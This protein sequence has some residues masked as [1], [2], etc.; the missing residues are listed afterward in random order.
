MEPRL[1]IQR[2]HSI[3]GLLSRSK[4]FNKRSSPRRSDRRKQ[5]SQQ[6]DARL[7]LKS[8]LAFVLHF[9]CV[10]LLLYCGAIVFAILEESGNL[11]P[12]LKENDSDLQNNSALGNGSYGEDELLIF[13]SSMV[14]K[15]KMNV[16][17]E[18]QEEMTHHVKRIILTI[19]FCS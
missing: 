2:C 1:S 7:F 19:W 3:H 16:T 8:A 15:Y 14:T 4:F 13:W 18:M 10:M 11:Q 6:R 12:H 5:K 9:V 17:K